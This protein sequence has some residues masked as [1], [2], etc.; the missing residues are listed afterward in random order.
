MDYRRRPKQYSAYIR[1]SRKDA[2]LE[3]QGIDTLERHEK[4][5]RDLAR[6]QELPLVELYREVVS[7][8]SIESR[9]EMQRLL[10]DVHSGKWDGVLVVELERLAR[11]DTKDQGIVAEAF[12]YSETLIIT[13]SKTYDPNN[14][15][16]EEYFEFGLFMSRREY[17]T[18]TRRMQA[19]VKL[20]VLEGNYLGPVAPYGY[21]ILDR[22]RRDRTLVPNDK[23]PIVQMMFNW[24]ASE[25]L[26]FNEIAR[27]LV[28]MGER[29][30]SGLTNWTANTVSKIIH[31][32]VYVGKVRHGKYR[33]KKEY[34][35]EQGKIVTVTRTSAPDDIIEADGKH[36]PL[37][38]QELWDAAVARHCKNPK[39][40]QS[41]E[42][43]NPF[44]GLMCCAQCGSMLT[45]KETI[46][47]T[48]E[49]IWLRHRLDKA[50]VCST[51][52]CT[53]QE[54]KDAVALSLREYIHDFTIQL[55]N[56]KTNNAAQLHATKI[57]SM[58]KNME[59]LKE[60]RKKLFDFFE[61][62]LYTE[63]EFLERK[64]DI[65]AK[66]QALQDELDTAR[67]EQPEEIDYQSKIIAFS[68]ALDAIQDPTTSP[69]QIN[70]LL[71]RIII[72]IAYSRSNSQEPFRLDITLL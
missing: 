28:A 47:P 11:G 36:P 3:A 41:M 44:A 10:Q 70:D 35:Q 31:N 37:V 49:Y 30:P 16:D 46:R 65:N 27:R 63:A 24:Y 40:R 51:K 17:K 14:E 43:K 6:K 23:A 9:P 22:G 26:P 13:P 32:D 54:A 67:S 25:M 5:L 18:I 8:D 57:T 21:D 42:L 56:S 61:N 58:E 50:R 66:I 20:S 60:R 64:N 69:K 55:E 29:T 39:I 33:E 53:M 45:Y 71:K 7:G 12:K 15:F 62:D 19:G 38:S 48:K 59:G 1:K 52:Y 72:K 34:S 68:A 2:D 4:I